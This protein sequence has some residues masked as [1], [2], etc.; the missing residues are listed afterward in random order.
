MCWQNKNSTRINFNLRL[1]VGTKVASK[2]DLYHFLNDSTAWPS[3]HSKDPFK[4]EKIN[5][6]SE[7]QG[8]VRD[9]R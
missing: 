5:E 9:R 2:D 8:G 6:P 7:M 1:S 4:H 3:S